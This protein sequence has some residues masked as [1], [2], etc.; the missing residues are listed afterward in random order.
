MFSFRGSKWRRLGLHGLE[1]GFVRIMAMGTEEVSPLPRTAEKSCPFPVN[2]SSPGS[3]NVSMTFPTEPIAFREVDE[4]S[5]IKP[6]LVA[7]SCLVAIETPSH[8]L[9]MMELDVGMFVF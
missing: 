8:G 2:P 9:S 1:F 4:V 5:V 6:Q 3:E 7:I